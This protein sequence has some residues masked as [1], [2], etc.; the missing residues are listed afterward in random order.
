MFNR[1]Y[2]QY[3]PVS[4]Y[5]LQDWLGRCVLSHAFELGN[6][7]QEPDPELFSS[8]CIF[9]W[10]CSNAGNIVNN[11]N[12]WAERR[13]TE[14]GKHT[15]SSQNADG[16]PSAPM[17]EC[18]QLAACAANEILPM[19]P[20]LPADLFTSCLTS[21]IEIALRY[22]ALQDPLK[23]RGPNAPPRPRVSVDMVMKIPG[24]L[25]DRRTPLGELNWIFTS[26]TDTIAWLI[27]PKDLFRRLFRQ[28]L[29]VAALFRNFLLAERIMRTYNCTP[30]SEPALPPTHNH[31]LWDSWD[32]TVEACLAQLPD[33]LRAEASTRDPTLPPFQY[34]Y[35]P[36]NFYV[37]HLTALQVWLHNSG[38]VPRPMAT[39]NNDDLAGPMSVV[40]DQRRPP[41]QLPIVLQVLLSQAHRLRALILLSKFVDL[42]PWAVHQALEIGIFP[43]VQRLLQSPAVE[44]RPVL[45]FIWSRILAV[46]RSCQ[47]DLLKDNGFAYFSTILSPFNQSAAPLLIPNASEHR[48]MCAFILAVFCRDFRPGQ[49]ALLTTD[50]C[51]ACL[52]R[53]KDDD[54]LLRQWAPL[55]I[56]QLWDGNDDAKSLG[57]QCN[58]PNV[59][60]EMLRD[61][62]V[63]VRAAVLYAL[64][65]FF[66]CSGS[67]NPDAKGGGGSGVQL[68]RT[69][70]DQLR[71]EIGVATSAVLAT[72]GDAS[73][74][75]RK[76]LV[77]MLSAIVR[78]WRGWFVAAAWCYWEEHLRSVDG[79]EYG[80]S[81][82]LVS[83]ALQEWATIPRDEEIEGEME[84]DKMILS[85]CN[86]VFTALLE[87]SVDPY[88]EVS[89]LACTVVDYV[90]AL[91]IDSAFM[92]ADGTKVRPDMFKNVDLA[93][94]KPPGSS[95][96]ASTPAAAPLSATETSFPFPTLDHS[97][98]ARAQHTPPPKPRH[99]GL[100]R[101]NS[102]A[103]RLMNVAGY[104]TPA[105]ESP[106]EEVDV[107]ETHP[108]INGF[109]IAHYRPPYPRSVTEPPLTPTTPSATSIHSSGYFR[110]TP[111]PES[112]PDEDWSRGAYPSCTAA[113]VIAALVEE[114]MERLIIR[115]H[116]GAE[117][118]GMVAGGGV[119]GGRSSELGIGLVARRVKDDVLP[120]KSNFFDWSCEYYTESQMKVR[121]FSLLLLH[122]VWTRSDLSLDS[123][124][125]QEPDEPGSEKYNE[126]LW[127]RE[128][129]ERIDLEARTASERI[130][131]DIVRSQKEH[132]QSQ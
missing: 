23:P 110:P 116:A 44:L 12:R 108:P 93:H 48:A 52:V 56:A 97:S 65:T 62:S 16:S 73:P 119:F 43:Y 107:V 38:V 122:H 31:P 120:L 79:R 99:H 64:G 66:G 105:P 49:Q 80:G 33:L 86:T 87:L 46:D 60:C 81:D 30:R 17:R 51:A 13:D 5:D 36:S 100:I 59:L 102:V 61:N 91:L 109:D 74:M 128:R 112:E 131:S 22:Y 83:N 37:E 6:H 117:A 58:A 3:I 71:T 7:T 57:L 9:V 113:E 40:H 32:L 92:T 42:G 25:K 118:G 4:L 63:E 69:E 2:T 54:Y 39:A 28:D 29:L 132:K 34:H 24:D 53:L 10:D 89:T 84:E 72:Y 14:A 20:D 106:P 18:I 123:L 1:T 21:P 114:D 15:S 130:S 50:V 125:S 70:R 121:P 8:P 78:E 55:C 88:A 124:Q 77:V 27:F 41:E 104:L 101:Q 85:S 129:N 68:N 26:V 35:K 126:Q 95:S 96:Y 103:A 94:P 98:P 127:R 19:T 75:V 76:E 11:F 111:D 45:I 115:R 47:A 90:S 82:D 67:S